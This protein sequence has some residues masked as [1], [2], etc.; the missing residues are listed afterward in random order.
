MTA[1]CPQCKAPLPRSGSRFCNQCGAEVRPPDT[2]THLKV[3]K[4]A[5]VTPDSASAEVLITESVESA[6]PPVSQKATLRILLREGKVIERELTASETKIGK[7]PVNDIVLVDPAVSALHAVIRRDEKGFTLTDLDSRNGTFVND[8]RIKEQRINHGDVIKM[9]RCSLTFRLSQAT[10]T[11]VLEHSQAA[12]VHQVFGQAATEDAL[13]RA[14]VAAG[15]VDSAQVAQLRGDGK[16]RRLF[17]A[18]I[19]DS[20]V[21]DVRLR[22]LMSSQFGIPIVDVTVVS[23]D[24]AVVKALSPPKLRE[25]LIFPAAGRPE[26]LTL[27]MADPTDEPAIE[28]V[29]RASQRQVEVRLAA[30][31][32]I[33]AQLDKLYAPRLIGVFPSGE[34]LEALITQPEMEIGKASHNQIVLTHPTVSNTHAVILARNGGYTIVDLGSSNGTYVNGER[35]GD[36]AHTLQHGDKIQIAEVALTFRN[37]AETTESKTARLSPELLEEIRRRAG[38]GL[39]IAAGNANQPLAP[40]AAVEVEK[41]K[42]KKKKKNDERLKAAMI[43]SMGR[44]VATVI[45]SILT[46]V[47]TIYLIGLRQGSPAVGNGGGEK[48]SL[49]MKFDVPGSFTQFQGGTFETSGASW[50]E[51]SK[52]VLMVDDGR[53]GQLLLMTV[54]EAGR[55]VGPITAIAHNAPIIDPEGITNDG[56]WF[57]VISSQ[58]DPK[59]G[60]NNA[61]M[62]FAYDRDAHRI[63]GTPDVIPDFRSLLLANVP[64]LKGEGEKAGVKGGLNIEGITWDPLNHRLLLGLR[65]PLIGGRAAIIPI[66]LKD[67]LGAFVATNVQFATPRTIQLD[68]GGQGIRDLDYDPHLKS[69]VIISGATELA[70][71][72][73][74]GLWEWSG[75]PDQSKA[76]ARPRQ[77]RTLDEAAKPEGVTNVTVNGKS[78]I[79]VVGDANCYLKLDYLEKH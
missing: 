58:G 5:S 32:E 28:G 54:N 11:A 4:P 77:E 60:P 42:K 30:A 34:K 33:A 9:G 48:A 69:F 44:M 35:L 25:Q 67:P 3:E 49:K 7:G 2:G 12:V 37:P 57:Y 31:G 10:E 21:N 38:L 14:V 17:R 47:G 79:L 46:V 39:P 75:E 62:R 24:E 64:E 1:E 26:H 41:E 22:D 20:K 70:Q 66:K 65:S 27:V 52:T 56:T 50:V 43:N 16:G 72:T 23:L 6:P 71:R 40:I 76:D 55:Q 36:Q 68:L 51:D 73:D 61:L 29:K 8:T 59:N 53:P 78:F 45:G 15:L 13:A 19:E 18:L 74:F 63:R